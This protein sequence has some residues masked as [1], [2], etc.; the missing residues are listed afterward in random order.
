MFMIYLNSSDMADSQ[1]SQDGDSV[2][3]DIPTRKPSQR[4]ANSDWK[5][6]IL[7]PPLIPHRGIFY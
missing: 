1:G 4:K 3:P 7:I 6:N 2:K 5:V